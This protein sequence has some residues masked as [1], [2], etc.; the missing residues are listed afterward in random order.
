MNRKLLKIFASFAFATLA[1]TGCNDPVDSSTG[2]HST[3]INPSS[4]PS[5]ESTPDSSTPEVSTPGSSTPED[6][7]SSN[8]TVEE[9]VI[10]VLSTGNATVTPSHA[11]AAAG[12]VVTLNITPQEGYLVDRVEVNGVALNSNTYSF[13][14]PATSVAINVYTVL[15]DK[16]GYIVDGD[17]NAKL[18]WDEQEQ[19][20]VAR[21][22]RVEAD[23]R[24]W[25]STGANSEGLGM[26][27]I[28]VNKTFA[29]IDLASG[30]G[31]TVGGNAIY[32]FY[33]D[34]SNVT[35]PIYIQ[36][37]GVINLPNTEAMVADLFAGSAKSEATLNP[38]GVNKV[39][40]YSS[41]KN[42]KYEWN[43]YSDN[44]SLA[45]VTHPVTG[46]DKGIVYKAQ[47]D[48]VY[49]LVD[50]YLEGRVDPTYVTRGDTTPISGKYDIVSAKNHRAYQYLQEEVDAEAN[51]YS[52]DMESLDFD[53][54]SAYRNGFVGNIYNDVDVYHDAT[55]VSTR[56]PDGGFTVELDSWVRWANSQIY[57]ESM[58]LRNGYVTYELDIEFTAAGAI[59]SG[60]Y[61]ETRHDDTSYD[62]TSNT[63]KPGYDTVEP[64]K[65]LAFSYGYGDAKQGQPTEDVSKYF[66]SEITNVSVKGKNQTEE[67]KVSVGDDI[68]C[69]TVADA[70]SA[71]TM[72]YE[73]L[74]NT[75]LDSW[76]YGPQSSSNTRVLGPKDT[77]S[78]FNFRAFTAGESDVVIGN[79]TQNANDVT[80]TKKVVVDNSAYVKGIW[81][82]P[83][84]YLEGADYD[85]DLFGANN[86][87]I[88]A[89]RIYKVQ[90]AGSTTGGN[91]AMNGLDLTFTYSQEGIVE[92]SYDNTTGILTIDSTKATNTEKT[93][94]TVTL[95][96]PA[97]IADWPESKITITVNPPVDYPDDV[98]GSY[99]CTST[100]GPQVIFSSNTA[101]TIYVG[102][103]TY[104]F[105]CEYNPLDGMFD[106]CEITGAPS[107]VEYT[108][109]MYIDPADFALCVL[110]IE[111]QYST[112][113]WE[114]I[115]TE[116]LGGIVYDSDGY[117]QGVGYEVFEK[118]N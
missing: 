50:N 6:S 79:H 82:Y 61:V 113:G 75:A 57:F 42:E 70:T 63:L 64:Y 37:V 17:I 40:Y 20:Y 107:T 65:T 102:A 80:F 99:T 90:V 60:S 54:Y 73:Y 15:E 117:E 49:V 31:F 44:S 93:S 9:Y 84:H 115:D 4:Q 110:L 32:D 66:I 8:P 1:L 74:P 33:Y 89:G 38:I 95:H 45:K 112:T 83:L 27:S 91:Y 58:G 11:K 103:A 59:K 76:Q 108:F 26:V 3:P 12:E 116:I 105:T 41:I 43:L 16:D 77:S 24:I 51:Q 2:E 67:G 104:S 101:G 98:V 69:A 106:N 46:A 81:M 28:D 53:M 62:F 118:T 100:T 25:Y 23:S 10:L 29:N 7:S 72:T 114:T 34:P 56:N 94:V 68:V 87:N 22:V 71:T 55:I 97:Q 109:E 13:V 19:V 39:E 85:D 21:N 48:N 96:S 18:I 86:A 47:K 52:H 78:P 30:K 35:T 36:R 5:Q 92:L 88:D 14:M 111:H